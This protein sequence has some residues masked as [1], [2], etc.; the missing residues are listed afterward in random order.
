[1]KIGPAGVPDWGAL[2]AADAAPPIAPAP[3]AAHPTPAIA[4]APPPPD[5]ENIATEIAEH[6]FREWNNLHR[7]SAC[8]SCRSENEACEDDRDC[9]FRHDASHYVTFHRNDNRRLH[10][11]NRRSTMRGE[12]EFSLASRSAFNP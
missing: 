10:R 2:T 7:C 3:S 5:V 4:P 1:M 6:I 11:V 9:S 8:G 12:C